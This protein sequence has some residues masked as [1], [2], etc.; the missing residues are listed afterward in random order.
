MTSHRWRQVQ[1]ILEHAMTLEKG[2][3]THYIAASCE[4]DAKLRADVDALLP[5]AEAEPAFLTKPIFK[6]S[7]MLPNEPN[8]DDSLASRLVGKR[9]G[10][11]KITAV[12]A[13]GGMGA[14]YRASRDDDEFE[15][16]VA[17]K[18]IH[19]A[20]HS[21]D[22]LRRFRI[23]RQLL[24]RLEHPN[25][26]RLLDG[27][28]SDDGLCYLVMELI[29]GEPI[30]TYCDNRKLTISDRLLLFLDVCEA[31]QY[32]HQCLIVHRDLKPANILITRDGRPKLLDFGIAKVLRPDAP[33]E[34]TISTN[35]AL[36]PD[37]AS[38]EQITNRPITTGTDVYS[39]GVVLF[40]LLTGR[41]PFDL[42]KL[43]P[44]QIERTICDTSPPRPSATILQ[45]NDTEHIA[46]HR[47]TTPNRLTRRLTG[48]L[49]TILGSTLR[50]EPLRR[51]HSVEQLADDLRRHLTGLPV[52]AQKDTVTYRA[53]KF[54]RRNRLPIT[55]AA[56]VVIMLGAATFI[57]ARQAHLARKERDTARL[58][59]NAEASARDLAEQNLTRA[60]Q[61]TDFL[62]DLFEVSDP[63]NALGESLTAREL[64]DRGAKR[65]ERDLATQPDD[66]ALLMDTIGRI[67]TN[68]GLY[69]P[70][71]ELLTNAHQTRVDLFGKDST[72]A[73]Q[74]ITRLADLAFH[75]GQYTRAETMYQTALDIRR[76]HLPSVHRDI[77]ESL[78][79]LGWL[80][81]RRGDYTAAEPLL[82]EA[83][84]MRRDL[85]T[86]THE[87][88]VESMLNL[89]AL[90]HRRNKVAEAESLYRTALQ[91]TQSR[92]DTTHPDLA[93]IFNSLAALLTAE[94]RLQEAES[95]LR[96]SLSMRQRL[97]GT[98]HPQTASSMSNLANLLKSRGD[99]DGAENLY[100]QSLAIRQDILRKSHPDIA[101]SLNNLAT[102][103]HAKHEY[104]AAE[105]A[106][107]QA[108]NI[109]KT[110][111]G[112][113]HPYVATNLNNLAN[114]RLDAGDAD[115]AI[116]LYRLAL[117]IRRNTLRE[118]HPSIAATL[119]YLGSALI[120]VD[121]FEGARPFLQEAYD[122]YTQTRGLDD[123]RTARAAAKLGR[124]LSI[125]GE[126]E[127]A[128][129]L[130]DNALKTLTLSKG[131]DH[132]WTRSTRKYVLA[133]RSRRSRG[134][135][136]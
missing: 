70:A 77:A 84:K 54:I 53:G 65:V 45:A 57:T 100:R 30:D 60:E 126:F 49:D 1:D 51:Y 117:Q 44:A 86:D 7:T 104:G 47:S 76:K 12:I 8:P 10:A 103:L 21:D 132:S 38:P 116:A 127:F 66:R 69:D 64:L 20:L 24:A 135:S 130:L 16:E 17:V 111:L 22:L 52:R 62:I 5:Y 121:N 74:S 97:Y 123:P 91:A 36:T 93:L 4:N 78:N 92:T 99:L 87:D 95:L 75:R 31:L 41:R 131:R 120:T 90:C 115:S 34:K 14:V 88:T 59:R 136:R 129:T 19:P 37:Y 27:G 56:A 15:Q 35:R 50:K 33:D 128:D 107:R 89:A 119:S 9:M 71:D 101:L 3:R 133:H 48:D 106:Y 98:N 25:I 94:N 118:D 113:E 32:A 67:Y 114:V 72:Q 83:L 2:D 68:L 125:H 102:C 82:R 18:I 61:V 26:A 134:H 55:A 108:L 40:E 80:I 110:E 85:L 58:A 79:N 122:I 96:E 29:D 39:L 73:A 124:C 28:V 81:H 63:K 109:W 42:S 43:T 105:D 11:Y 13:S 46:R 6:L 23:E 112:A